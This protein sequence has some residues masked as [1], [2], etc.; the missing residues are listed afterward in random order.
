MSDS[1][2]DAKR[3][4]SAYKDLILEYYLDPYIAKVS[5]LGKPVLIADCFAGRGQFDDGEPGSPLIIANA[6][7]KWRAKGKDV[8]AVYIEQ[9]ANNYAELC[10]NLS[11]ADTKADVRYG[12]FE[13]FV[14]FLTQRASVETLFLY[15]D[16]YT[17]KSLAFD[18]M[19]AVFDQIH[20]SGSSV[21]VL[22]NFNVTTFMRWALAAL[23]RIPELP[24][25]ELEFD[26]LADDPNETVE[27]SELTAIAGG[28]YWLKIAEDSELAFHEKLSEFATEY[29][30]VLAEAF[31]FVCTY[32]VKSK[33]EHTV[34]KYILAFGSRHYDGMELMNDGMC[35]AKRE[36]LGSEFKKPGQLFDLTPDTEL[37]DMPELRRWIREAMSM[38]PPLTRKEL[39][40]K[41]M[42]QCFCRYASSDVNRAVSD[43]VKSGKLH[44]ETGKSRMNDNI[45]ISST[46]FGDRS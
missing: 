18:R 1:F 31:R 45:R 10:K 23:K 16:P 37:A 25:N 28:E 15:V 26:Y 27:V 4:W 41:L 3:P 12:K 14:D 8:S 32:G 42:S 11:R 20:Q 22:M 21:E 30:R 2:F 44:S 40:K 36:F 46:P 24:D 19:K 33:Y 43:L 7:E 34:P 35:K 39:R 5:G 6:I 38:S 29:R 13:D 17:V 9:D